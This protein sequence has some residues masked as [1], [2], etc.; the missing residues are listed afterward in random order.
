[1]KNVCNAAIVMPSNY[2]IMDEEEMTYITG[3]FR[4]E[5]LSTFTSKSVCMQWATKLIDHRTIKRMTY[6][7][8]A[9]EIYA[10][11]YIYF[12][13]KQLPA[14]IKNNSYTKS[15]FNSAINGIDLAHGG[16]TPGRKRFYKLVWTNC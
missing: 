9:E 4:M 10:H 6:Q 8:L 1:M 12:K 15:I 2:S 7:E 14:F 5:I 13:Y 11:A 16:D 3:G